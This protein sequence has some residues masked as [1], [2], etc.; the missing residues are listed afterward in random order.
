M[1]IVRIWENLNFIIG[2]A[3]IITPMGAG[4]KSVIVQIIKIKIKYFT[5]SRYSGNGKK[6]APEL[7]IKIY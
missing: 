6:V 1:K 7:F 4:E 3:G 2:K 5:Q